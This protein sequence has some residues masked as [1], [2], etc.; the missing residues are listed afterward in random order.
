MKMT[1]KMK[2]SFVVRDDNQ[3]VSWMDRQP[4]DNLMGMGDGTFMD[5]QAFKSKSPMLDYSP[6]EL[7]I[8]M[9]AYPGALPESLSAKEAAQVESSANPFEF[10]VQQDLITSGAQFSAE[11]MRG[12]AQGFLQK[13]AYV[14]LVGGF[15][16]FIGYWIRGRIEK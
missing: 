7:G 6:A 13:N 14:I 10:V 12:T 16:M 5:A 2:D 8:N 11:G 4:H 3:S 9:E 15:L 1:E